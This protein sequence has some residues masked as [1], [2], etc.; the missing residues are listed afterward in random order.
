MI[1]SQVRMAV[2]G[3]ADF[4]KGKYVVMRSGVQI[5]RLNVENIHLNWYKCSSQV[6]ELHTCMSDSF[7]ISIYN[8]L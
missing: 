5:S 4:F 8:G 7:M 2:V 3:T 6:A 1:S